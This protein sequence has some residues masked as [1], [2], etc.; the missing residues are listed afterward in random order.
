MAFQ[1]KDF[2]S[3]AASCI[4]WMKANTTKVT[5][6]NQGSVVRT[7]IEAPAA[8]IEELY[9]QMVIG[10]KEA[11]PVSVYNS[12]GFP[13]LPAAAAGGTLRFTA[14]APATDE[15][16][17]P[18]GSAARV[19]GG[20]ISYVTRADAVI[21]IG[22]TYVDVVCAAD[23]NGSVGNTGANTITEFVA[24]IPGVSAVTNQQPFINGQDAETEADRLARFR[25]YIRTLVRGTI[26][27]VIYGAK[28]AKL[29]DGNGIVY[30]R[31]ASAS[32]VEP[33]LTDT[34]QPVARVLVYIHNGASATSA[35]LVAE[36]QRII[37]G[38]YDGD[39]NPVPGWKAAGVIVVV[40]AAS[41]VAQ[42]VTGNVYVA[43][44]F[45]GA[46]VVAD[47]KA[48]I[49][50]YIQSL[51]AGGDILKA[52]LISIVKRD[53]PGVLNVTISTPAG[54]VAITPA[55]KA[56]PGTITLTPL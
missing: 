31:A 55:Q 36:A 18:I 32:L 27:A 11:I 21:A 29:V 4:N 45:V 33:Y 1:I 19:P 24:S 22:Q 54:D 35:P 26:S 9:L 16:A 15:I 34:A 7:M 43:P 30:E 37:D 40:A 44:G 53:V 38:Y 12:F 2:A 25:D 39:G 52:E 48:A 5:D 47:A 20:A 46:D 50:V 8:E 28:L 51:P 6:F 13:A 41:D 17:I 3:I 49:Q 42:N 56:I 10:L 14:P 23:V